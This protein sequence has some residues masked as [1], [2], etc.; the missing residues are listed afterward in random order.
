[1]FPNTA[2]EIYAMILEG[3]LKQELDMNK[4]LPNTQ[5][6]FRKNLY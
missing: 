2:Y 1:M 6:G 3:R 4:I 5:A